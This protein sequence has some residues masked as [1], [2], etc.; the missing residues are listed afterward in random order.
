MEVRIEKTTQ[1]TAKRKTLRIFPHDET[2]N[3]HV[4]CIAPT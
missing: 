1:Q 2:F 3:E 4:I